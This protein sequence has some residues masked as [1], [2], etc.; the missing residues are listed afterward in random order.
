MEKRNSVIY[1]QYNLLPLR[2]NNTILL[3]IATLKTNINLIFSRI[4]RIE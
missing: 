3:E 4:F 2:E 1:K